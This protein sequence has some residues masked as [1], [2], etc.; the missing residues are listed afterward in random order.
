MRTLIVIAAAAILISQHAIAQQGGRGGRG[1]GGGGRGPAA[2]APPP[3]PA[4]P[5]FECFESVET[6]E[7]PQSALQS[8]ID[9]TVWVTLQVTPQGTPDKLET[10]VTSAWANG[11][12]LFTPAVEKVIRAAKFKSAC[13]G[14]TV[15]VVYR[16]E[17]HGDAIAEPKV[18]QKTDERVMFIESQPELMA[19]GKKT[20]TAAK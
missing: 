9:A 20:A 4:N 12:K 3:A 15:G 16:Y 7:F 6:P 11:P 19:A 13:A 18:T 10:K 5:G 14:K 1:G 2:A 17:L 8:R